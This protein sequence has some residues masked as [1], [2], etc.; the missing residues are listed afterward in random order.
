MIDPMLTPLVWLTGYFSG[1][2]TDSGSTGK[3][4]E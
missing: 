1:S 2:T 4:H 3:A